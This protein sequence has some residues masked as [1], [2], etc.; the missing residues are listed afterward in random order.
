MAA[1]KRDKNPSA[2]EYPFE[3]VFRAAEEM[4]PQLSFNDV[5]VVINRNSLRKLLDFCG[6]QVMESFKLNLLLVKDTLF[7]ERCER[8]SEKLIYGSFHSG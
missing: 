5:D 7:I 1:K 8:S 3:I 2:P 4:N 6:G